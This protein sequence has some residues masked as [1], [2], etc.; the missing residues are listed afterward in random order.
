MHFRPNVLQ[1]IVYPTK[2]CV[3]NT[4]Q[5]TIVP[6]I[7]PSHTQ[8]VNHHKYD[9]LHYYPHTESFANEVSNQHFNCGATPPAGL[10]PAAAPVPPSAPIAPTPTPYFES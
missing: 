7:H 10:L 9:H 5:K 6:H 3:N 1:P 4:F 8:N 2:C